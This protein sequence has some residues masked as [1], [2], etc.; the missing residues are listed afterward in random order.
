MELF[1]LYSFL[2]SLAHFSFQTKSLINTFINVLLLLGEKQPLRSTVSVAALIR[3]LVDRA[4]RNMGLTRTAKVAFISVF[5]LL[6]ILLALSIAIVVVI[7]IRDVTE[8]EQPAAKTVGGGTYMC[9]C[10]L[11]SFEVLLNVILNSY[12]FG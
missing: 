1:L 11:M 2:C 8:K 5:F 4:T 12:E 3:F 6:L 9:V 10:N 7:D